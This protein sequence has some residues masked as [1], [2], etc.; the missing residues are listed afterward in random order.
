M[1]HF[2][3][4]DFLLNNKTAKKLY[5]NYAAVMPI[6]DY[7]SHLPPDEIANDRHFSNLTNIWLDGDHYKW[8]AMRTL[9]IDEK[10]ITGDANDRKKFDKWAYTVPYTV[11]NPLYHWS[12][13]EL[14]NYF[15]INDLINPDNAENI[16]NKCNEQLQ[17]PG[18]SAKS[19]LRKMKVKVVCT[20][21]NPT[22]TLSFHKKIQSDNFEIKVLP[23]FRPDNAFSFQIPKSY[24]EYLN[25]LEEIADTKISELDDLIA[26]LENR[27]DYFHQMGCRLSDHGLES[28]PDRS[29]TKSELDMAF[30][31]IRSGKPVS[32]LQS[33]NLRSY[34]LLQLGRMYHKKGWVQQFHL[35]AL[36]DA[37]TRMFKKF[38]AAA[39]FDS[40]GD[41]RQSINLADFL[42]ELDKTNQLAKTILYNLNP[43]DNAVM[44]TMAGNFNDGSEKG[45]V[46]F[47]TAWWFL[48]QKKG[49]EE[50][51]D[52]LSN[53]GL[54]SCFVGML[55][56]SRSFLSY[57]R[58][59]YFRRIL[60]NLIG[61][62][63]E[64][65]ELPND[66]EWLGKIVS[67]IC[68]NNAKNY[69][70]F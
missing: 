4:E 9:G 32:E 61:S 23:T 57:P 52:T 30:S 16:Y 24:N 18:F 56:D 70:G 22:D 28:F 13:L 53:M 10:Y 8:R 55:T 38:G 69:F 14:K 54:L 36:R 17:K 62:D 19:L 41:F 42:N 48:D 45:K 3:T 31:L 47:G 63:V 29:L 7:H 2:L 5:H 58:H 46:Q 20:T 49:M 25:K 15:G 67:D 27:V 60:C 12:H 64:N 37:N 21:D 66:T 1:E 40:V 50:Q 59:E 35:G 68:Y 43:S 51:I 39:G 6:I 65:G 33:G 44:A 11:R 26:A 34:I